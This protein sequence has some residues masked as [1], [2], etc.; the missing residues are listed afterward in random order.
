MHTLRKKGKEAIGKGSSS[1]SLPPPGL[2]AVFPVN[3]YDKEQETLRHFRT[4]YCFQ[5]RNIVEPP[6]LRGKVLRVF[7]FVLEKRQS[8]Q[9]TSNSVKA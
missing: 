5:L 4:I 8:R 7:S 3:P 2:F 1:A 6:L 9:A